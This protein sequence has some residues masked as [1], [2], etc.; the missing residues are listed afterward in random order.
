MGGDDGVYVAFI[1]ECHSVYAYLAVEAMYGFGII[2]TVIYYVIFSV[3]FEDGVMSR[4]VY[5]LVF[6]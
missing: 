2:V 5:C 6:I 1:V 4:S 3:D